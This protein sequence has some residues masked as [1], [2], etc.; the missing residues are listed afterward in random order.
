MRWISGRAWGWVAV[1]A[2][3]ALAAAPAPA[4][5]TPPGKQLFADHCAVCHQ[6]DARGAAGFA[7]S[8]AGT[9][10]TYAKSD[11]GLRYM[12]QVP[13]TGM[14][15]KIETE[16]GSFI[17]TMP[18]LAADLSDAEIAAALNYVLGTFND[19]QGTTEASP[20]TPAIVAAARAASPSPSDTKALRAS[21]LSGGS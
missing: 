19:V 15:G 6:A 9:L 10:A 13:I 21:L 3:P 16:G 12:A 14:S 5:S 1:L 2:T 8:L 11:K 17:G 18:S 4:D 7:P 20:V